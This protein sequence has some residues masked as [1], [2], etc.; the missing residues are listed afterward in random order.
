MEWFE[1]RCEK[2]YIK[3]R[4]FNVDRA[5][6]VE[7]FFLGV[8][9]QRLTHLPKDGW[10]IGYRVQG[11]ASFSQSHIINNF[12]LLIHTK[13]IKMGGKQNFFGVARASIRYGTHA[14]VFHVHDS[15]FSFL[16]RVER[17]DSW[18]NSRQQKNSVPDR[19]LAVVTFSSSSFYFFVASSSLELPYS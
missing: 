13:G 16:N 2:I 4:V 18:L 11:V 17:V 19:I 3:W 14:H 5:G 10:P 8:C 7:N 15:W 1:C 6:P 9:D 12:Y